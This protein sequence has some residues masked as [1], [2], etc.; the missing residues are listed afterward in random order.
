MLINKIDGYH[1]VVGAKP[2]GKLEDAAAGRHNRI[3][4]A[5]LMLSP[6]AF[7]PIGPLGEKGDGEHL[8]TVGVTAQHQIGAIC[9]P[10][11][12]GEFWASVS[13]KRH[14]VKE[15]IGGTGVAVF[16]FLAQKFLYLM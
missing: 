14:T 13:L 4:L 7:W 5:E 8:P 1:F 15:F 9:V 12:L 10:L 16:A 2:D 6:E 11:Y 3:G